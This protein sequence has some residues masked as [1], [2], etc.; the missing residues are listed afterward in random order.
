M[1]LIGV[2]LLSQMGNLILSQRH[3]MKQQKYNKQKS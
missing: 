2:I 3:K 1:F